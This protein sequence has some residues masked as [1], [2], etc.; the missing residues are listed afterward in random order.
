MPPARALVPMPEREAAEREREAKEK[1]RRLTG[2]FKTPFVEKEGQ[3]EKG[4]YEEV[5]KILREPIRR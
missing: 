4:E 1:N 2:Q 5:I 3:E